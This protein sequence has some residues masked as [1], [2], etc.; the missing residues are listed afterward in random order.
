[1]IETLERIYKN[2]HNGSYLT[3]AVGKGWITEREKQEIM[4][5]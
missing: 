1:M 5:A 3:A 4:T 2:T